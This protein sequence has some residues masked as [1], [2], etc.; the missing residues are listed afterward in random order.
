M[1]DLTA[2]AETCDQLV[3]R[4]DLA[5]WVAGVVTADGQDVRAGGQRS[6]DGPPM[7][8]DT[9]FAM[10]SSTKPIGGVLALRLVEHLLRYIDSQEH[11]LN[12]VIQAAYD[13]ARVVVTLLQCEW[14]KL[15]N[16]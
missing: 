11:T 2:L 12:L 8:T 7:T 15:L 9:Q 16:N 1:S 4:G 6:L 3:E 13:K 14:R 5:G 10:S